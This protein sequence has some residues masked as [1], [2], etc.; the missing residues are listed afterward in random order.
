MVIE[1]KVSLMDKES[2]L[3]ILKSEG[4]SDKIIRAFHDVRRED[5]VPDEMKKYAYANDALPIGHQQTISQPST[6]AFMLSLLELKDKQKILEVGSG[7][8]YVLALMARISGNSEIYGIERIREL[9]ERSRTIL[10][11]F[12]NVQ[13]INND[14]SKGLKDKAP[15]DRILVSAKC[16][17]LPEALIEQLEQGGILVMPLGN[18]IIKLRKNKKLEIE[19]YPGFVFVPLI[20]D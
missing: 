1:A 12:S 7:S 14:G 15:F 20:K 10:K 5:F 2:M 19:E 3:K 11:N 8:G 13:I 4:F 6:I 9:A 16:S 17:E 18:S